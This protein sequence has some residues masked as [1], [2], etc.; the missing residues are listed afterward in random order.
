MVASLVLR[1]EPIIG[2]RCEGICGLGVDL[3]GTRQGHSE[4]AVEHLA[5]RDAERGLRRVLAG[6]ALPS[7]AN[8]L[9]HLEH[10]LVGTSPAGTQ[11]SPGREKPSAKH[12]SQER[13]QLQV[14]GLPAPLEGVL[15]EHDG[16]KTSPQAKS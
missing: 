14:S 12:S 13:R 10:D 8:P 1:A 5:R 11:R 2:E 15:V 3:Q 9:P 4:H 6:R 16:L 7:D